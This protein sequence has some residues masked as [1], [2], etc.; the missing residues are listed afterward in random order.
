MAMTGSNGSGLCPMAGK[1]GIGGS[2]IRLIQTPFDSPNPGPCGIDAG[3]VWA[4]EAYPL[5]LT[6]QWCLVC[7]LP[8]GAWGLVRMPSGAE[9][10]VVPGAHSLVVPGGAQ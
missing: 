3:P 10:L 7:P 4:L 9:C 8:G 6:A 2:S 5:F 1:E